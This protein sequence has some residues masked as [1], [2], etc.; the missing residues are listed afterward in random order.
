MMRKTLYLWKGDTALR[1]PVRFDESAHV[2]DFNSRMSDCAK[3]ERLIREKRTDAAAS[4]YG[5]AIEALYRLVFGE[6]WAGVIVK[7]YGGDA[8]SM[9]KAV[10]PFISRTVLA[11]VMRASAR[12]RKQAKRAFLKAQR[13]RPGKRA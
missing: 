9:V 8:L 13:R 3:M 11:A 7:W 1:V 5:A 12:N 4:L 2:E 10:N 6:D